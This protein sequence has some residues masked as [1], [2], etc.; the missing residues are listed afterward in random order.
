MAIFGTDHIAALVAVVLAGVLVVRQPPGVQLLRCL[1]LLLIMA[2]LIDP[3]VLYSRAELSLS[4][5]LPLELCDLAAFATIIALWT[6]RQAAFE[7]AWFWGLSGTL[8]ALLTPTLAE[9]FPSAD[10]FRFVLLHGVVVVGA[11]A[12]FG[13]GMRTRPGAGPRVFLVTAIYAAALM[14]IDFA[15]DA[16]YMFLRSRPEGSVLE[17]FGPWPW[18]LIAAAAI[19]AAIF[20]LLARIAREEPKT[21]PD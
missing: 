14:G 4:R 6:R 11:L 21:H 19:A 10:Y 7:F 5:A 13:R 3:I 17:L 9:G 1:A 18:Y 8:Q 16:N 15:I 12:L 2:E 20:W